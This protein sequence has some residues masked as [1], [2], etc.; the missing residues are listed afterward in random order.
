MF[1]DESFWI[2]R[3]LSR[4]PLRDDMTVLDIGSSTLEF[5]T[6]VQP[7]I[8]ENVFA[9]L[10]QRGLRIQHLDARQ[11]P[12]VDIVADVT[13]LDRVEGRFDLVLCANLLEHV[14]DRTETIKNVKR[15]VNPEGALVLT[16]PNRYPLH[17][18]PI[19]T[20]F[21]P[22]ERELVQLLDWPVIEAELVTVRHRAHYQG[23]RRFRRLI[24][25]WR[26]ACVLARKPA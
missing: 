15:L 4:L 8:D 21:R 6:V 26:I 10:R 17:D 2:K 11:A 22:T 5:R 25:P 3:V 19:D 24:L 20:G 16:V 7:H 23:S 12:G 13:A 18:D 1:V 14:V 9:P